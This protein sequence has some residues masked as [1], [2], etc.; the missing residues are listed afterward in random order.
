MLVSPS[1]ILFQERH[2]AEVKA[3]QVRL[4]EQQEKNNT[5][6][7]VNTEL[8]EQLETAAKTNDQLSLDLQKLSAHWERLNSELKPSSGENNNRNIALVW[9]EVLSFRRQMLDLKMATQ[10]DLISMKSDISQA[11]KRMTSACLDVHA[12]SDY[13]RINGRE[14]RIGTQQELWTQLQRCRVEKKVLEQKVTS[15]EE[16][17]ISFKSKNH[18]LE[19]SMLEE[20]RAKHGLLEENEQLVKKVAKHTISLCCDR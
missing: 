4:E 20:K 13:I 3:L 2:F 17:I 12:N 11:G 18:S 5:L 16:K 14:T 6:V 19:Q 9:N 1:L 15:L 10:R 7:H 8:R